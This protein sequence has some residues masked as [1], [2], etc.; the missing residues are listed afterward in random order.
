MIASERRRYILNA[1]NLRGVISLKDTARE[2]GVAE[3]TVRRDF[4]KLESEGKLK[5]VQG[6]ATSL[7]E[8]D[9]AELTM[10]SKLPMH[11]H[12]KEAVAQ[13]AADLVRDGECVFIDGGTTMVPFASAIMRKNVRIITYNTMV[14]KKL[15]NP[16]AQI[17]LIGGE[18]RPHYEMNVGT[19]AQ[20]MLQMF[21]FDKAFFGCSGVDLS[22][23]V[24]YTTETESLKMKRIAMSNSSHNFLLVDQSKFSSRGFLKFCPTDQFEAILSDS[25]PDT[26]EE[27][28]ENLRSVAQDSPE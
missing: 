21:Y 8:L 23:R 22:Q 27:L 14:L 9:G 11:M 10:T 25:L 12:G 7:E 1:L 18:Y 28:P 24:A 15:S 19:I 4:E 26:E 16:T 6:G 13:Y 2:L 20:D 5:R 17:I 3:I